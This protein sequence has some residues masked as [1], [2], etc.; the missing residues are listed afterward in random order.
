M[1]EDNLEQKTK[2]KGKT[3]VSEVFG[4]T[5]FSPVQLKMSIYLTEFQAICMEIREFVHILLEIA[6]PINVLTY[7]K[8]VN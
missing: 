3:Y 1:I 7:N 2:S 5:T 4:S 8:S 6:K